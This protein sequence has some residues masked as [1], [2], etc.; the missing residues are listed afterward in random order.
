MTDLQKYLDKR[1]VTKQQM[2]GARERTLATIDAYNLRQARKASNLTQVELAKEMG[3]SQN[4]ISRMENGD[5]GAMSL[6][7][8]RRYVEAVGGTLALVAEL[9]SGYVRLA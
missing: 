6:D 8:I 2:R 1:G 9:P 4:R 7:V 3:V 5:I